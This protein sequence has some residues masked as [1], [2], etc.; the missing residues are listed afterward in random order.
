MSEWLGVTNREIGADW[1]SP[2]TDP[3]RV[4]EFTEMDRRSKDKGLFINWDPHYVKAF[5]RGEDSP[6]RI[7]P[8]SDDEL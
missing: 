3:N 8:Y 5:L 4:A 7:E 1:G 6:A 2:T